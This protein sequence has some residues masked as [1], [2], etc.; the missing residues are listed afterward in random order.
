MRIPFEAEDGQLDSQNATVKLGTPFLLRHVYQ[1]A[2]DDYVVQGNFRASFDQFA[3]PKEKVGIHQ[4]D[5]PVLSPS[6]SYKL[7]PTDQ[8]LSL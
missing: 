7:Q 4:K 8:L 5:G 2:L 6:F 1:E 3:E